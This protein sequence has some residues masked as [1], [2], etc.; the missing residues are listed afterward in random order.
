MENDRFIN[1]GFDGEIG[2]IFYDKETGEVSEENGYRHLVNPTADSWL[3]IVEKMLKRY[4]A[5]KDVITG[6]ITRSKAA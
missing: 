3:I 6:K 5:G 1:M 4:H 2:T